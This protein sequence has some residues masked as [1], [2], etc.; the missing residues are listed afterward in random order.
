MQIY[1]PIPYALYPG[2]G[3]IGWNRGV[4]STDSYDIICITARY[5][6]GEA[7]RILAGDRECMHNL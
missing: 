4:W 3:D 1:S 6:I 2:A 7:K 5:D